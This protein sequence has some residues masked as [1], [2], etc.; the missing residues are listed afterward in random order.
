MDCERPAVLKNEEAMMSGSSLV[1][2]SNSGVGQISSQ[3]GERCVVQKIL[4]ILA[5]VYVACLTVQVFLA[6]LGVF[7]SPIW[8]QR[9]K[10]FV[11]S[12]G[13]LDFGLL[14][15]A[16]AARSPRRI[17]RLVVTLVVLVGM[18]YSTILL[19]GPLHTLL[20]GAFHPVSAV[21]LYATAL[22]LARGAW[23]LAWP[24]RTERADLTEQ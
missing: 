16:F 18:Q 4:A 19:R 1:L 20:I 9:H 2:G 8:F 12:F 7:V 15:L 14:I 5:C 3:R 23:T 11:H 17:K 6:G 21:L 13:W 24:P 10:A 22:A